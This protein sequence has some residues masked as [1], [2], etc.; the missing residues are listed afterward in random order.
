[1]PYTM[2]SDKYNKTN[3]K[4]TFTLRVINVDL[5]TKKKKLILRGILEVITN[6]YDINNF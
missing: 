6:K 4:D 3:I 2:L 1:M 5:A